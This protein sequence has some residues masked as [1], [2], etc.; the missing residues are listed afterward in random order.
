MV[1][2]NNHSCREQQSKEQ[3]IQLTS[4][5]IKSTIEKRAG[6]QS[7][8][9]QAYA[10][11]DSAKAIIRS[12]WI[13]RSLE[14]LKAIAKSSRWDDYVSSKT[15]W[16]ALKTLSGLLKDNYAYEKIGSSNKSRDMGLSTFI[17]SEDMMCTRKIALKSY[18]VCSD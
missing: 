12:L 4:W 7:T 2:V 5:F 9:Q 8:D 14:Q 18:L 10:H 1:H 17:S 11:L 15:Y 16:G 13:A 3:Q 6:Q